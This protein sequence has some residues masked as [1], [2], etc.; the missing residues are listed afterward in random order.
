M[1]SGVL[2]FN[3]NAELVI[4]RFYKSDYSRVAAE[5]FRVKVVAAKNFNSPVILMERSSFMFVRQDD[6]VVAAVTKKN[7]NANLVF[8]FLYELISVFKAYFEGEFNEQAIRSNFVLVYE[9][10]D[11]VMDW[12]YPQIVNTD[13]LKTY[14]HHGVADDKYKQKAMSA[15][16]KQ[17]ETREITSAITGTS[18]WRQEGK[19]H[20]AK[21]EVYLDVIEDVNVI[22]AKSG[23]IL[24]SF[25]KGKIRM[26]SSLSGMPICRFGLNDKVSMQKR[27]EARGSKKRFVLLVLLLYLI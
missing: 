16:D 13:L 12:G 24:S 26:K 1:I 2:V 3:A 11:E 5:A 17:R 21:N 10:F 4:S 14:I 19:Y 18:P 7:A 22:I 25:C 27:R 8:T 6:L 9:L 20:Y 23:Q 15:A